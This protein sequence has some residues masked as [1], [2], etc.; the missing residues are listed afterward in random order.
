MESYRPAHYVP[1]KVPLY[2]EQYSQIQ[3]DVY[4]KLKEKHADNPAELNKLENPDPLYRWY[5]RPELPDLKLKRA[6]TTLMQKP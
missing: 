3:Q 2:D 5:H 1:F 4:D 6:N